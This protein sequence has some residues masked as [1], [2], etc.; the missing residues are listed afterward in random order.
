MKIADNIDFDESKNLSEQTKEFQSWYNENVNTLIND[1][2][3]PDFLDEYKR[4]KSYTVTV[5]SFSI[6]IYPLYIYQDQSNWACRDFQLT[7]KN[8]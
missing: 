1:T 4:P 6:T 2:L 3:K 8:A 7:I 5:D